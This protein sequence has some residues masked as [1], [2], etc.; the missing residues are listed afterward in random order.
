MPREEATLRP[1]DHDVPM[2]TLRLAGALSQG[3]PIDVSVVEEEEVSIP[4]A[5][6]DEHEF[7]LRAV[8]TTLR[9]LGIEPGDLLIIEPREPGR[10]STGELVLATVAGCAFLGRWWTKHGRR[11][12]MDAAMQPIRETERRQVIGAV[13]VVVRRSTRA[14]KRRRDV[15]RLGATR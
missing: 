9:A 15:A 5:Q 12:L 6:I 4:A 7:I 2:T 1:N 14:P 8:G 11:V 10:A 3:A 13:T